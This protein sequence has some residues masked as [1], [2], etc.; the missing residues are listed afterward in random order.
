MKVATRQTCRAC[1]G[2]MADLWDLGTHPLNDFPASALERR[3]PP[4]PLVLCRCH[5]CGLIQLQHTVPPEWMFREHYWYRSGVNESMVAHLKDLVEKARALVPVAPGDV[6]IDIGANDG[7]LLAQYEGGNGH[8]EAPGRI[9]YE[10]ALNLQEACKAHANVV[11]PE[12]FPDPHKNCQYHLIDGCAKHIISAAMFYDLDDPGAFVAE[13]K[14]LL[15]PEGIWVNQLAYL[16]AMLRNSAFDSICH[17]HLSYYCLTSLMPL[18]AKHGL[19]VI[20]VEE[21]AVNEG[22]FRVYATHRDSKVPVEHEALARVREMCEREAEAKYTSTN[23][24]YLALKGRAEDLRREV[25]KF[26]LG[27]MLK[28]E[29]VDLLGA[30]TK[31]NVFLSY[32]GIDSR[33]VRRAIERSE[34][35]VG[36]H[37]VTG[38]PIVS[39]EEG[40]RDPARYVLCLIWA[41]RDSVLRRERGKWPPGTRIVFPMP[42]MEVVEL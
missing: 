39:E 6:V 41:F 5:P 2:N 9:A 33:M 13:V 32:C 3:H 31:G 29:K 14:R 11:V 7:T 40:R 28:D 38:V 24:A 25:R 36:R 20:D 8:S 42:R 26:F 34:E 21:V 37:T 15:H 1:G 10:P 19:Q 23:D 16:P 17:E 35:K 27:T 30:S 22:S 4:A 18:L 12:F